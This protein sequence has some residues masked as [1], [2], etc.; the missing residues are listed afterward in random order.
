MVCKI[1]GPARLTRFWRHHPYAAHV[2]A[3]R[4]IRYGSNLRRAWYSCHELIFW[5][6]IIVSTFS[7]GKLSSFDSTWVLTGF[8]AIFNSSFFLKVW[9]SRSKTRPVTLLPTIIPPPMP[10]KHSPIVVSL[11]NGYEGPRRVDIVAITPLYMLQMIPLAAS[12]IRMSMLNKSLNG[13]R[14]PETGWRVVWDVTL[15]LPRP[16]IGKTGR[17]MDGGTT[18]PLPTRARNVSGNTLEEAN[19]DGTAVDRKCEPYKR[20]IDRKSV[21]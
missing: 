12:R 15:R 13:F 21:V 5:V 18:L 11:R 10:R 14:K 20:I 2:A 1:N 17:Y 19:V 8:D 3:S 4:T 6:G 16:I 9:Y 7:M